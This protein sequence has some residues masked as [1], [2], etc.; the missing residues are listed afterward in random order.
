[1]R[2]EMVD[3]E[4]TLLREAADKKVTR[5][6]MAIT[7][8]FAIRQHLNDGEVDFKKVNRAILE[9]RSMAALR[10]IKEKAWKLVEGK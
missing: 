6:S 1:M 10:Y 8:A 5:D 4:G 9:H 3:V 2:V 7:Y